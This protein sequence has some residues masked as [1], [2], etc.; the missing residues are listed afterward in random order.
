MAFCSRGR[1]FAF[2]AHIGMR[3]VKVKT[4]G[5]QAF[6]KRCSVPDNAILSICCESHKPHRFP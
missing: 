4:I 6:D 1:T 2:S 5:D 3:G